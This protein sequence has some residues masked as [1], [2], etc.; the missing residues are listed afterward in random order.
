MA[1]FFPAETLKIL[2][3]AHAVRGRPT[4]KDVERQFRNGSF[5]ELK[6]QKNSKAQMNSNETE[7]NE[8]HEYSEQ[9]N[10]NFLVSRD[11]I[12]NS[13]EEERDRK[14]NTRNNMDA[15]LEFIAF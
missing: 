6:S 1:D 2:T 3:N 9:T 14:N 7:M 11:L 8:I 10:T 15:I 13:S 5:H 12:E 4:P